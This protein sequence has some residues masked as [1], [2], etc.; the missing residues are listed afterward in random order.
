MPKISS[1]LREPHVEK[2]YRF[3]DPGSEAEKGSTLV[4]V[5]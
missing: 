1:K 5:C 2:A 4:L 3:Q